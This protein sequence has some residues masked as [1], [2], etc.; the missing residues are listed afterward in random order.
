MPVGQIEIGAAG[1]DWF[2][3]FAFGIQLWVDVTQDLFAL[4]PVDNLVVTTD[5]D[6][7]GDPSVSRE[8]WSGK[9]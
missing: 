1:Q 5:F 2:G 8:C 3:F 4:D 6:F 7:D 9:T